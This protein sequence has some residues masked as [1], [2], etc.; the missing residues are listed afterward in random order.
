[1]KNDFI[2]SSGKNAAENPLEKGH[3]ALVRIQVGALR[4]IED[5]PRFMRRMA[6]AVMNQ[7]TKKGKG[8]SPFFV[9]AQGQGV[10]RAGVVEGIFHSQV[11]NGMKARENGI[12]VILDLD[13]LPRMI[14]D[15]E[16]GRDMIEAII[17]R[18]Q[19]DMP[20]YVSDG[21][22]P[23][24]LNRPLPFPRSATKDTSGVVMS[25]V[26]DSMSQFDAVIYGKPGDCIPGG[27]GN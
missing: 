16:Y 20:N 17:R 25:L 1:M 19:G 7:Y 26:D 22:L 8:V 14:A 6:D 21:A 27:G 15:E 4:H 12:Y 2:T 23:P 18:V 9:R 3:V 13:K 11:A 10:M 5:D 24:M